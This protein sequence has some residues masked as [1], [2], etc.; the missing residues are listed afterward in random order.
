MDQGA[1]LR[2]LA[3]LECVGFQ[4]TCA[5]IHA[6]DFR[7][8]RPD[9]LG[10]VAET[11]GRHRQ[12]A[13]RGTAHEVLHRGPRALGRID[14]QRRGFGLTPLR[15]RT[16]IRHEGRKCRREE[17]PHLAC[18]PVG[19]QACVPESREKNASFLAKGTGAGVNYSA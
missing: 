10:G 13:A 6:T 11:T 3:K 8:L 7:P 18:R 5:H 1:T 14:Q 4:S 15:R 2:R 12:A 19:D 17:H 16:T 9:V